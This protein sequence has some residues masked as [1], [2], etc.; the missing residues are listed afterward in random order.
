[1]WW[2]VFGKMCVGVEVC[3]ERV[4]CE[5]RSVQGGVGGSSVWGESM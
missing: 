5:R 3:G 1:M 2:G 4:V